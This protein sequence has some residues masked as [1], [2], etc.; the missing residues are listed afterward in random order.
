MPTDNCFIAIQKYLE[1]KVLNLHPWRGS[2]TTV[3]LKAVVV[4]ELSSQRRDFYIYQ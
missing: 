4:E 1:T 3:L 2:Q